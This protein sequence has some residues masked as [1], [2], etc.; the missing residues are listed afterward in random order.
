[1]GSACEESLAL[2]DDVIYTFCEMLPAGWEPR[3]LFNTSTPTAVLGHCPTPDNSGGELNC[4]YDPNWTGDPNDS[5]DNSTICIDFELGE[6]PGESC[7]L[8]VEDQCVA[9]FDITNVFPGGDPRTI[10]FW[11]NHNCCTGGGQCQNAEDNGGPIAGWF[12]LEDLLPQLIGDLTVEHCCTGVNVLD[13]RKVGN[14]SNCDGSNKKMARDAAYGLAAQLLAAQVN[15]TVGACS[16]DEHLQA[17]ADAQE[18]LVCVGFDGNGGYLGPKRSQA[19]RDDCCPVGGSCTDRG[20]A[21][22][23]AGILDDYN[24]GLLCADECSD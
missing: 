4:L 10:G 5:T 12:L 18:L 21:T 2:L 19:T 16:C 13:K 8:P 22:E 14:G 11:K 15:F 17:M 6:C 20:Y 3:V 7:P 24:N 9:D 1:L 23:L